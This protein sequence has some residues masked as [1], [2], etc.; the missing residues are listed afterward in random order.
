MPDPFAAYVAKADPFAAYVA[1]EAPLPPDPRVVAE[2]DRLEGPVSE[3]LRRHPEE[4]AGLEAEFNQAAE[5]LPWNVGTALAG[6]VVPGVLAKALPYA[7]GVVQKGVS[8]VGKVLAKPAVGAAIGAATGYQTGGLTGAAA[9]AAAGYS[10]GKLSKWLGRGRPDVAGGM[11][12]AGQSAAQ[13][14]ALKDYPLLDALMRGANYDELAGIASTLKAGAAPAAA[15]AA[16]ASVSA[17]ESEI[18]ARAALKAPIDWRTTDVTPIARPG[19]GIH[20]GD[21]STP[22]LLKML[23]DALLAKDK[24]LAEKIQTAIRQ[25]AHITG[26]VGN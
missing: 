2:Q 13:S 17:L 5:D 14:S 16:R 8:T 4:R 19:K 6:A 15:P 10:G 7:P 11:S 24:V 9:G 25:R 1:Q 18:A 23:E 22:G 12:R 26:K 3:Y 21:E 20:F